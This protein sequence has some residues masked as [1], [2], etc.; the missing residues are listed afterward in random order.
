MLKYEETNDS[1]WPIWKL[2]GKCGK[3]VWKFL[4]FVWK[5]TT[6]LFSHV[7]RETSCEIFIRD[8]TSFC[9]VA[10][11]S[12]VCWWRFALLAARSLVATVHD[13]NPVKAGGSS[14]VLGG[15]ARPLTLRWSKGDFQLLSLVKLL[16]IKASAK[17]QNCNVA[18]VLWLPGA[19]RVISDWL[20]S[21][22]LSPPCDC[23]KEDPGKGTTGIIIGIHIGV[24]CIIFCVLF[25]MFG[26]R[27]RYDSAAPAA[28]TMCVWLCLCCVCIG[29][30][31]CVCVC[32]R[33][34]TTPCPLCRLMTCK[35]VQEQLAM[36][37]VVR[38]T[39]LE[40]PSPSQGALALNMAALPSCEGRGGPAGRT[41]GP[42]TELE[43]LFPGP[44][45][46]DGR[47]RVLKVGE[48]GYSILQ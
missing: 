39:P 22:V 25:L 5:Y 34:V 44:P 48:K 11:W 18:A 15:W 36:P 41:G 17:Q 23:V 45:N 29:A 35:N 38:S 14:P 21:A 37:Q 13:W 32:A 30:C 3:N 8:D 19:S 24:T 40:D 12:E 33:K 27:G 6:F 46:G 2:C 9:H 16:W 47:G 42:D 4:Y 20:V 43:G 10:S 26:Y 28:W 1:M 7:K 31:V